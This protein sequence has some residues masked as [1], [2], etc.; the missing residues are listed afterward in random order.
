MDLKQLRL[1]SSKHND[2]FTVRKDAGW[3]THGNC[4]VLALAKDQKPVFWRW[5]C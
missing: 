1:Y 2:Q 3:L 5:I 4:G